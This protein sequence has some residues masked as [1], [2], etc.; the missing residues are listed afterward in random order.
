VAGYYAQGLFDPQRW[1]I[2]QRDHRDVGVLLLTAH[3]TGDCWELVYM[4]IVPEARGAGLG[5]EI[6]RFALWEASQAGA[7]RLVLAVD[8]ANRPA[9][10][11]YRREGFQPWD[12]RTVY[13]RIRPTR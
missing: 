1:F 5:R 3:A 6:L 12:F 4:G 10:D 8:Q 7:Q 9:S 13:A 2:V 11:M